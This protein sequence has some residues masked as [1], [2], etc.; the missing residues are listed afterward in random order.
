LFLSESERQQAFLPDKTE[1]QQVIDI[2]KIAE[3]GYDDSG[4]E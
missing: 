2:N 3:C 4:V 1:E